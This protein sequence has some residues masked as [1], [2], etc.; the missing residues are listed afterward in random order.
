MDLPDAIDFVQPSVVQVNCIVSGDKPDVRM[1]LGGKPF[2]SMPLGTGFLVSEAA[3]VVTAQHV[4]EA[5]R[6]LPTQFPGAQ[7][8]VGIGIAHPSTE[9]MRANFS[10]TGFSLIDEDP[11]HDLALLQ[12]AQNPFRGE[13][14]SGIVIDDT[15]IEL[16]H[17]VA[18]MNPE[19]PR[20][21]EAIA[22]SGYPLGETVLLTSTGIV[23]SSWSTTVDEMPHPGGIPNVT[24]PEIRD[25]YLADVQ[26][27]PGNSGGPVYVVADGSVLG[28][29][30][31]GKLTSVIAG[32]KPAVVDHVALTADAGVSVV[33]P[34]R[35]VCEMLDR[36][37]V[38]WIAR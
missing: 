24:I 19:R 22:V 36:H 9:N 28:V 25:T 10:V 30:V 27:N 5:A 12:M 8:Q 16:M 11:G 32:D 18:T 29:L 31:A 35:Y 2:K 13:M 20:D 14:S 3:H 21:G 6:A 37:G 38:V 17:R 4:I 7:I 26:T 15:P 1:Q 33:V 23:A 34:T